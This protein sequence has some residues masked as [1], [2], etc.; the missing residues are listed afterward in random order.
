MFVIYKDK[1]KSNVIIGCRY[2][3]FMDTDKT[4][5]HSERRPVVLGNYLKILK[6]NLFSWILRMLYRKVIKIL[7]VLTHVSMSDVHN[8]SG[9]IIFLYHQTEAGG[10]LKMIHMNRSFLCVN[11]I[12]PLVLMNH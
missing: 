10:S 8:A 11:L 5:N 2:Y 3:A 12:W 1:C 6:L 4:P 7:M 9:V